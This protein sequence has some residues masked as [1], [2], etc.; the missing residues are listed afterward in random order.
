MVKLIR[1]PNM[2]E[3][4]A[5][6]LYLDVQVQSIEKVAEARYNAYKNILSNG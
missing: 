6:Q 5:E 3:D 2:I 1:N 4:L